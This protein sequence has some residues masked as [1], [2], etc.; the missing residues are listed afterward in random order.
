[1][2]NS[3]Q[4]RKLVETGIDGTSASA[5]Q[6]HW[7]YSTAIASSVVPPP[8]LQWRNQSFA[9]PSQPTPPSVPYQVN[10]PHLPG[11]NIKTESLPATLPPSVPALQDVNKLL[12][13]VKAGV[14]PAS[15]T[16]NNSTPRSTSTSH[17]KRSPTP[18]TIGGVRVTGSAWFRNDSRSGSTT[19]QQVCSL[20]EPLLNQIK[21]WPPWFGWAHFIRFK[22]SS[23]PV[24]WHFGF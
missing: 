10:Q 12:S 11:S 5:P 13:L 16:P 1:M 6:S 18:E 15:L 22:F 9:S 21:L 17:E 19:I 3:S 23:K 7:Y 4:L 24:L 2:S 8:L 14:V 20:C